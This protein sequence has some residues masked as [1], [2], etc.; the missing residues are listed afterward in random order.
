MKTKAKVRWVAGDRVGV[1]HAFYRPGILRAVCG[2][3][4]ILERFAWPTKE[5]CPACAV[6]LGELL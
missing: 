5:R 2:A 6:K 4:T 1:A 3:R